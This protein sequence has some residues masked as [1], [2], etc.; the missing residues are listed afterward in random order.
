M[1]GF[2]VVVYGYSKVVI[3]GYR[4]SQQWISKTKVNKKSALI[5]KQA[6]F[7]IYCSVRIRSGLKLR[8]NGQNPLFCTA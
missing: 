7:L 1:V 4:Y 6:T 3:A 2:G 5:R 8:G